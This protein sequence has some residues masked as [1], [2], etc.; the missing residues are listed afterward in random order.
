MKNILLILTLLVPYLIY[1][2]GADCASM[3]PICTDVGATFTANTGTTSEAGNDYGCLVTQPNPSWYYF[4]VATNGNID[5]SLT[6]ASDIDFI[7]WGPFANLAA[8]QANCGSLSAAQTVDCSFSSTNA[9][10]PSIPTAV[11][12]EV[13]I[14]LITNYAS[15]VQNVTLT[16]TGGTGSTDCN[17]VNNPPCFMN[18][19]EANISACDALTDTYDVT[20]QIDFDDPPAT[21]DLIVVDCNGNQTVVASAPFAVNGSGAGSYNYTLTGSNANGAA[22]D[23]TAYFSADPTCTM[24]ITYTAPICLCSFTYMAINQGACDPVTNTFDVSGSVEFQS[25]PTTG[26]LTF[27]DC[28]GNT[29]TYFAPFTSPQTYTLPGITPNGTASCVV[30]AVFSADPGCNMTSLPFTDPANCT[31]PVDIGTFTETTTGNTNSQYELCFGDSFSWVPNG[32]FI[33]HDDLG[34]AVGTPYDP[35]IEILLFDCPPTVQ[36]PAGLGADPCLLGLISNGTGAGGWTVTNTTGDGLTFWYAPVSMYNWQTNIYGIVYSGDVCYDIG[37]AYPL[38]FLEEIIATTV[39]DCFTGT[40][41][42]TISGGTPALDG[43]NFNIVP[44]TLVPANANFVNTTTGNFGDIVIDGLVDGDVYS[45]DVVD[46]HD[47]P[48]TVSGT[49][50]GLEDASFTYDF[51]YCQDD[52]DPLPVITGV[53]GGTFTATPAG[54]SINGFNGLIDLS[55][56]TPGTYTIQYESPAFTCWGTETF[57]LTINPQPIVIAT[58]DSPICD[59]GVSTITLNETGGE[60]TEWAW[61][62]NG[63]ATFDFDTLQSPTVSGAVNGETFTVTAIDINTGCIN[64]DQVSVIVNPLDDPAFTLTDFCIGSANSATVTGTTGGTFTFAPDLLDGAAVNGAT[65]EITNEVAGTTYTIQ[66]LTAGT[67]PDSSTQ[68]VTVNGLPT[69]LTAD[70]TVCLGGNVNITASGATTYSWS[71]GTYLNTTVGATVTSTPLADI[72]YTITGTDANGCQNTAIA[73]V[74]VSGNAPINAGPDV[75][76]CNG[77]NTTLTATGGIS[78][79]WDQTLGNGNNFVVSPAAN[80]TYTVIGI[81]A[82][83]CSGTDQMIVTVNPVPTVNPI[84]D[85]TLCAGTATTAVNFTGAVAG[86]TYDW[87][88]NTPAIGLAA[89]GT[90]N[91]AGFVGVNAGATPLV[92]TITVTPS[93]NGCIGATETFTITINPTPTVDPIADQ[94]V[95]NGTA[96]AN[97]VFTGAVGGT[98]YNWANTNGGI[99]LPAGGAGN[100]GPFVGTNAGAA[101]ISGT[102]TVT[103]TINGCVGSPEVFTITVNPSPVVNPI[104]DET[105]CNG[106]PTTAVNFTST[107]A[108]TTFAWS[109]NTT[110]IGL[111]ASGNGN[112]PSFNA[113]NA[114][115]TST[116]ATITVTPTANGCLGTAIN[117]TITVDPTP[118]VNAV[119]D[120]TIC[121]GEPTTAVNFS[122]NVA[123]T[124]YNWVNTNPAIGLGAGA[125]GNIPTFNGTNAGAAPI[126]GTITV[127]PTANGCVGTP[128]DFVITVNPLPTATISGTTSVCEND[129]Q[130]TITFTGANGTAPYTFTYNIN[131]TLQPAVV[132]VGNTAT[133]LVPT[134]PPGTYNYNLVDVTDASGTACSQAQAGT[135]TI[136]VNPNPV[137]VITGTATYCTGTSATLG[138]STPFAGYLW[139]T[140]AVTPNVN[141]TIADNPITVTVT[142]AFGCSGT[143]AP[144]N[145]LENTVIVYTSNIEIC[146]GQSVMIHGVSQSTAGVYDQNFILGTG[147]DSTSSV[148]L[149]VNPLPIMDA[150]LDQVECEGT[151]ITLNGVGAPTIAWAPAVVNGTPF[152]QPVGTVTYTVTGTDANG[153][154]NTD[155]VD[156]TINPTPDVDPIANQVLCNNT[157]TAAVNF[158]GSIVGTTYNWTNNDP[159]IGLAASGNGN[160]ASF[161]A[162]NNGTAPVVATISVTPTANGCPG[163]PVDFTITVNP[164]PVVDAILDQT[165]CNNTLSTAVN[166]T[167]TTAGTTFAWTNTN[168]GIGLGANGNGAIA[169]FNGTN[170]G[171][172]AITGTI[173][174]TPTANGCV[175]TPVD[176]IITV[177]PSPTVDPIVDQ[178]ICNNTNTAAVNFTSTT[179]GST[180]AWAN[181]NANIGLASNGNGNIASFLGTNAGTTAITGTITVTPT[182]NGCVGADETFTITI[183]P[184]PTVDPIADQTLCNNTA[185]NAVNFTSP[186]AGTTF[187][188]VNSNPAIGLGAAGAG[189]IATFNGTNAGTASVSGTITVTPTANGCVGTDETFVITIDPSPVVDLIADQV[190][191]ENIATNAVNFS[192]ATLGTAFA[193]SNDTP[194]IGLGAAGNGDILPFNAIN[195]GVNP[196]IATITITPTAN[197]CVGPDQSFTITINP[198][199]NVDPIADDVL[200]ANEAT[201]GVVFTSSSAGTAFDWTNSLTSI[202]LGAAGAGDIT[203]FTGLNGSA[204]P[205]VATITVTPS[206]GGCVGNTETFTITVNPLPTVFAGNDFTVCEGDQA[207]LTASGALVYVWTAPVIDGL[208]FT[209]LVTGDYFVTGTD[210]NGCVGTDDVNIIVE[211]LPIVSFTADVTSGCAPL[212]VTFTNTSAGNLTDCIWTFG[213][214]SGGNDCGSITTTYQNG[215]TYDVS[216]TTTSANGCTSTVTY[217]DYIYVED[218]PNAAFTPSS[219]VVSVFNSEILFD[220]TSTGAVS[221]VWDFGD[222]SPTTTQENP[223]HDFPNEGQGTYLVELIAF[224]S[225][226]CSDTAWRSIVVNEELIFYVPNTFTPDSDDFNETFNAIFTTGYDPYDFNLFIFNRWGEVIWESHDD[227][228]GWD[229]TYGTDG[230]D[231]QDG[232]YTWKIDFKTTQTDERI[233]VVGHVNVLR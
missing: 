20:G 24:N 59:D 207:V 214:G 141:V 143:S 33:P 233:L 78:Y 94:T 63:G 126:S 22:C 223:L 226:G 157:A 146:Q 79:T 145:V 186:S 148:T 85:Q 54:L 61:T 206:L 21:G 142:N 77:D 147:C 46:D 58:E 184:S 44:G 221:Y 92:A 155:Q 224:S 161:N 7:I 218:A 11:A 196:V 68:T 30:T 31:C 18:F 191:C 136:T 41:T 189:N 166:P 220:N 183:D 181:S 62:T 67:C 65:G 227:T 100:I 84:A 133:V 202:G 48:I 105:L 89:A 3:D 90:G 144:F 52:A 232:T 49:F 4:E 71:P 117:F 114:G 73:N 80:T 152:I 179:A 26:T 177:N 88:N 60:A 149:I 101:P 66:Y 120:Q 124:I 19:F 127:T 87:V 55:A 176:F 50:Q 112:I 116:T 208:A 6:A 140:G 209:P 38:T 169:A 212:E 2:Q 39:E 205:S 225:L 8:A 174:V 9:E 5:M 37:F 198:A 91:I 163:T 190:L 103:P 167:S 201:A 106:A 193:W 115:A 10:T 14:M 82:N 175:G 40:A 81:D 129:A 188:W 74:T 151:N 96:T 64:T 222:G 29:D 180:F 230:R 171:A 109:N 213:N 200:C 104:P 98:T 53:P 204:T 153:C 93:L 203:S 219:S 138:T 156:V 97:V 164:T 160:I 102:I 210:A 23:V 121:S 47:C 34:A 182:A 150:G 197:G 158:T 36:P 95:C 199:P 57:T 231:V 70:V 56:S 185:S 178:T 195:G 113:T 135:A 16:Q 15:V 134:T 162:V 154:Q 168:T 119:A 165:I 192:S 76:I 99:G 139:S 125:A 131:G 122:G 216:L 45:F 217:T 35:G 69:I 86:T 17:I 173:S 215:G 1:A 194:T 13:Y 32:D 130:P 43:S 137:P 187:D 42:T 75:T 118:T 228:V 25:P 172:A 128:T 72:S 51:K 83:G 27:T 132:S 28:E 211:P 12:G 170:A 123:G 110:S 111:G 229:A 159:S 108:G 107:T